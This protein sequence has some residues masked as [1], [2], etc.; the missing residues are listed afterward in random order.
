M[1]TFINTNDNFRAFLKSER[2][3]QVF[4]IAHEQFMNG[5]PNFLILILKE[6]IRMKSLPGDVQ[7]FLREL[8]VFKFFPIVAFKPTF[9]CP[10]KYLRMKD[11]VFRR[12]GKN[13]NNYRL[14]PCSPPW[15]RS[16]YIFIFR[17]Q[18]VH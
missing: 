8:V 4:Q 6:Q 9:C 12:E 1:F 18:L 10:C 3:M 17:N 13:W 5:R 2:D 14:L 11:L 16:R 15:C 7:I